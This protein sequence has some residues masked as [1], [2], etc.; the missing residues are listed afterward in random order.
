MVLQGDP[1]RLR[2]LLDNLLSNALKYTP[3]GGT[4]RVVLERRDD[5]VVLTVSDTGIGI[6]TD[7]LSR[8]FTRFFRARDAE[9]LAIQ[10]V[11]LGLAITKSII[12]SHDGRIQV[13]SAGGRGSTFIVR[14]PVAGPAIPDRS[15]P[16]EVRGV[17]APA[18][19]SSTSSV[20]R[21]A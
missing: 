16:G 18:G 9:S 7:D 15:A 10:G 17:P 20:R 8:L 5:E 13:E 11:G 14:L 19:A 21:R 12:E 1:T 6:S 2:Q 3:P 4:V